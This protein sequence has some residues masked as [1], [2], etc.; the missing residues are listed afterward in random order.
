ML[1]CSHFITNYF[2]IW[3]FKARMKEKI[4]DFLLEI[5][6]ICR[7]VEKLRVYFAQAEDNCLSGFSACCGSCLD[8]GFFNGG[9]ILPM[10]RNIIIN[11][12]KASNSTIYRNTPGP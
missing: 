7:K 6:L 10:I 3:G 1:I 11:L 4:Y 2:L 8:R 9:S 5:V 12:E